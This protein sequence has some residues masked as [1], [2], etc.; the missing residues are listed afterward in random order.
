MKKNWLLAVFPGALALMIIS[1][2]VALFIVKILWAWTIPD[3]FP[4]AVE[5][6]LVV[7]S[8]SWLTS[9]KLA[10]LVVV[11]AGIAGVR[12]DRG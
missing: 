4:G 8:I 2:V 1:L 12:K 10:I 5:Q 7:K 3:L 6:G 9:L 11:F